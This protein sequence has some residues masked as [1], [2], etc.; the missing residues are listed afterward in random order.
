MACERRAR[1]IGIGMAKGILRKGALC[2]RM[3]K[4]FR[5]DKLGDHH[6]SKGEGKP[7]WWGKMLKSTQKVR[8]LFMGFRYRFSQGTKKWTNSKS[9]D[10]QRVVDA[11]ETKEK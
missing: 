7:C 5:A 6:R 3:E 1:A 11:A 4:A 8:G 2:R 9:R 10:T